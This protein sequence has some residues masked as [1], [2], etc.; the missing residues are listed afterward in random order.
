M[1]SLDPKFNDWC[2]SKNTRLRETEKKMLYKDRNKIRNDESTIQGMGR[3]ASNHQQ[4][5][6]TGGSSDFRGSM[7]IPTP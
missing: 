3:I 2:P 1:N 6:E 7:V 4:L 5:E